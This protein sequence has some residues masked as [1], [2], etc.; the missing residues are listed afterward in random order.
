MLV[1]M[2]MLVSVVVVVGEGVVVVMMMMMTAVRRALAEQGWV[3]RW[4]LELREGGYGRVRS[5]RARRELDRRER[6]AVRR[7]VCLRQRQRGCRGKA[8]DGH[9]R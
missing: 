1:V 7:D 5:A 2:V 3:E 9:A 4:E 8:A 6:V